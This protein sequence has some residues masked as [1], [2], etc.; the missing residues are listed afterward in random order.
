MVGLR[1]L[2]AG[3]GNAKWQPH[4][5]INFRPYFFGGFGGLIMKLRPPEPPSSEAQQPEEILFTAALQRPPEE[6]AAYLNQACG[7]NQTLRRRL[8]A[9]LAAYNQTEILPEPPA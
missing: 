3:L 1:P 5:R 8:E 6:R 7:G 9:L 4:A 2:L